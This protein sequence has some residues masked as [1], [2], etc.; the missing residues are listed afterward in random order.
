MRE[1]E[2]WG[3]GNCDNLP[4]SKELMKPNYQVLF[5]VRYVT[6]L[7]IWSKMI[8]PSQPATLTTSVQT[9]SKQYD[10]TQNT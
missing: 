9:C 10:Q 2:R 3:E 4:V 7:N 6:S 1:R 5:L 8:H